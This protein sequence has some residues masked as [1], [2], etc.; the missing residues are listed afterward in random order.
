[1][2]PGNRSRS[3]DDKLC[4]KPYVKFKIWVYYNFA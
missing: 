4:N 3:H 2:D 1:V